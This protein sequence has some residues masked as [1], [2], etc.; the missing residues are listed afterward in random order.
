ML[1]GQRRGPYP[2]QRRGG[3]VRRVFHSDSEGEPGTLRAT[4][5]KNINL[6]TLT[7]LAVPL[8]PEEELRVIVA[9]LNDALVA[10]DVAEH[11]L[12]E[13]CVNSTH[14]RQS[15]LSAAFSGKLVPQAPNDERAS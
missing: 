4:A 5:Q 15:I 14:L 9:R 6:D 7:A 2:D 13:A 10:A 11:E 8:P 3:D 12:E 1:S